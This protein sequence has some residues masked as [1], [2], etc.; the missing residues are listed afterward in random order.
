MK[1]TKITVTS[2]KKFL[3]SRIVKVYVSGYEKEWA[4]EKDLLYDYLIKHPKSI[5]VGIYPFPYL[6]P[7]KSRSGEKYVRSKP[8]RFKN[9][10]LLN[11]PVQ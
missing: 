2:N 4:F 7:S 11:L 5:R 10:N 1:A 6:L 3:G 9:D 8:D